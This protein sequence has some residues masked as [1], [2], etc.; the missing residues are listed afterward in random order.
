MQDAQKPDHISLSTI[1]NNL[2][3]GRYVIPDFQRQFEWRPSD[4]R[5]LIRSIFLDYYIGSLLL[6]HGKPENLIALSCEPVYG[7][8]G[9][10]RPE[11]IV[12]DGQ[13]RLTAM[14]YAF[15]SPDAPLPNRTNR[16]FFY[17]HVDKFMAEEYDEAFAYEYRARRDHANDRNWQFENHIFPLRIV[18]A[19]GWELPNWVQDYAKYWTGKAQQSEGELSTIAQQH[20]DNAVKFGDHLQALTG[21]YQ[22]S[23]IELDRD[24]AIDKVC[25]IFTQINS[26]GIRLDVFDLLNALLKPKGLALKQMWR[27][28]AARLDKVD[29]EK[30]NV[31]VLQ[32]M[33]LL[34]QGLCSS[35]YLYF[36]IPEVKRPLRDAD[37]TRHSKVQIPTTEQFRLRWDAA[38]EALEGA[39]GQLLD[40]REFGALRPTFLP[41]VSILPIFSALR[42]HIRTLPAPRQRD[43]KSKLRRWY[44]A[45]VFNGRYSGATDSTS[46]RDFADVKAWFEDDVV[47]PATIGEFARRFRDLDLRRE[48][49]RGSSIYN[50][51]FNLIVIQGARDWISG[52]SP[53]GAE[54]DDHHIVPDSWGKKHLSPGLSGTI[55]NRTPLSADTNRNIIGSRLPNSYLPEWISH[56]NEKEVRAT[57]ESHF[58]SPLAFDILLREPF[59][60]ED[61][62]AFINERQ[63]TI[64]EAIGD[65]IVKDRLDLPANLRSLDAD[66]EHVELSLRELVHQ[67][68]G[69]DTGQVPQH[70][71]QKVDERLARAIKKS[72]VMDRERY[73]TLS[74]KLEFFDLR[75][76]Q[77][78]IASKSCWLQFEGRFGTKEILALKFDQLAEL[79]NGLRHSRSVTQI[80]RM[81]GE[82][83]ILWFKQLLSAKVGAV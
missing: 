39:I 68:F 1:V 24:L 79:R 38:V 16:Y 41:Y 2:R 58:I 36:L 6:W 29:V 52:D 45:S 14:Y 7:F 12:L 46:A 40:P 32:T 48:T 8:S 57:L 43:A 81:E 25:D 47:E 31:Y 70:V 64:L 9:P 74:G 65:L 73:A 34:L 71:V 49:K 13:Q 18:G 77:D 35:K 62:E 30:M 66:I 53:Q 20:A 51:I 59:G 75:E 63:R 19:T 22:I 37:G 15:I 78:T 61:F 83:A 26:R 60:P 5:E 55:L 28:A 33:S 50:G 80:T 3:E 17:V 27:E 67:T 42:A 4:I 82:A 69:G 11:Y 10:G 72:P 56:S 21:R 23:Y 44:W 76:L 54:L